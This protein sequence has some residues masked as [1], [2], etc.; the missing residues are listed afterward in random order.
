MPC[1]FQRD[2]F[3]LGKERNCHSL[4]LDGIVLLDGLPDLVRLRTIQTAPSTTKIL[5]Y[6]LGSPRYSCAWI[7]RRATEVYRVA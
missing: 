7:H 1:C 5:D 6:L 4:A 2:F 3:C